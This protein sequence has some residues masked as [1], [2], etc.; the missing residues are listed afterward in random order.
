ML[1]QEYLVYFVLKLE[2]RKVYSAYELY[3]VYYYRKNVVENVFGKIPTGIHVR[4]DLL[5]NVEGLVKFLLHG[6]ISF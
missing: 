3:E 2:P 6:Y 4:L 5:C 1:E